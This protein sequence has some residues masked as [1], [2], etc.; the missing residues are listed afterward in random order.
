MLVLLSDIMVG[1]HPHHFAQVAKQTAQSVL[2]CSSLGRFDPVYFTF[3]E[4]LLRFEPA[5][6]KQDG[7]EVIATKTNQV[8]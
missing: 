3:N 1:I 2:G 5:E 8:I 7:W 6:W 4:E